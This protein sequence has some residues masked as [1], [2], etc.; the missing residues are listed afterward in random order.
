MGAIRDWFQQRVKPRPI[1][2]SATTESKTAP[3]LSRIGNTNSNGW[4]STAWDD[5]RVPEIRRAVNYHADSISRMRL[6]IG[7]PDPTGVDEPEEIRDPYA[8]APLYALFGGLD[9]QSAM[10]HRWTQ[11]LKIVG[12]AYLIAYDAPMGPTAT[13][14]PDGI[15]RTAPHT[16][17]RLWSVASPDEIERKSSGKIVVP[18][19][20]PTGPQHIEID[21]NSDNVMIIRD[22]TPDAKRQMDTDSPVRSLWD[23]ARTIRGADQHV[24]A[25]IDSRLA[26][27]GLLFLDSSVSI[28][29]INTSTDATGDPGMSSMATMM[30]TPLH[31]R[32]SA[33]AIVPQ[34]AIYSGD[35]DIDKVAHHMDF[36]TKFDDTVPEI[37]ERGIRR[38]GVGLDTPQEVVSG[39]DDTNHWNALFQGQ[40][41]VRVA[42]GPT[43]SAICRRLTDSYLR[44]YYRAAGHEQFADD[45]MVWW[46][47]SSLVLPPDRSQLAM[48]MYA[49]DPALLSRE[50]VRRENGF[51]ERDAGPGD[52]PLPEP[53]NNSNGNGNG[54]ERGAVAATSSGN[55]I[56]RVSA[57]EPPGAIA[58][59]GSQ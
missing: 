44:P 50:A 17:Q 34:W 42:F 41:A 5:Y 14:G 35:K 33:S 30:T 31:D 18:F 52:A 45:Y 19:D 4:Q 6:Y 55:R 7:K 39:V 26:G 13:I 21:V 51:S 49:T 48:D 1:P 8:L 36:S 40:D 16:H 56:G 28:I 43:I 23:V 47:A 57:P 32:G 12:E 22:W 25:T 37:L 10:L 46:D 38:V 58:Q 9:R 15:T 59:S 20:T 27:A 54:S 24:H 29:P 53:R 3:M 11:L 2:R